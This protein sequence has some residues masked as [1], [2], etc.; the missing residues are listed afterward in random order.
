MMWLNIIQ[1][2]LKSRQVLVSGACM[3]VACGVATPFCRGLQVFTAHMFVPVH[4]TSAH[5]PELVLS[6]FVAPSLSHPLVSI[7]QW[8]Y[9]ESIVISIL[10]IIF[11]LFTGEV[12]QAR[13]E[14]MATLRAATTL[15]RHTESS[16][17]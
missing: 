5:S 4:F 3:A 12:S 17:E 10:S 1:A 6:K 14:T 15:Y 9:V 8:L 7:V 11:L 2:K 16:V 13:C